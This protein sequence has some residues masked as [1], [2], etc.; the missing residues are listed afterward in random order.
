MATETKAKGVTFTMQDLLL[1]GHP[2]ELLPADLVR[3]KQA[4]R[5]FVADANQP[6][7]ARARVL[8]V[9]IEGQYERSWDPKGPAAAPIDASATPAARPNVRPRGV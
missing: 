9:W 7:S 6:E 4:A 8:R 1:A 2:G 5:F 3:V